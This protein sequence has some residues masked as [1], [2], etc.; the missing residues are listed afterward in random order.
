M[1][2][3]ASMLLVLGFSLIFMVVANNFN[4][5][6]V[7]A[8]DNFSVYY[9][10]TVAH[11]IAVSGANMAANQIFF[12]VNWTTGF[13]NLNFGGG[14]IDASVQIIDA[15]QNIRQVEVI[16]RYPDPDDPDVTWDMV[17]EDTV[18]VVL[19]P[20]KFSKFAYFS[21]YE[22]SNIWWTSGDT[23]W[24]P[25]HVQGNLRVNQSPVFFGKVTVENGVVSDGRWER[26][27]VGGHWERRGRGR[28]ARWVW[29][30]DYEWV[31]VDSADPKFY[32]GLETGIDMDLPPDGVA[33]LESA[34]DVGGAKFTG[35]D[36]VYLTFDDDSLRFRF[37]NN[38]PDT[39]V[40]LASFAPN[41]VIFADDATVRIKG[42]VEGQYTVGISGSSGRGNVFLD[43]D[44]IYKNDPRVDPTSSDLLGIVAQRDV[45]ITDNAA[46]HSDIE[47]H[48]SIYSEEGGFGSEN[49]ASRPNSGSINLLGGIIQ[50]TRRAVGTFNSWGIVSGFNKKYRYDDRLMTASPPHFPGT[51]SYEIVSWYE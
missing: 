26:R 4:R 51:G 25:M 6:T 20:S 28:R 39:T 13:N 19:Q 1:G 43:D 18:R 42:V 35:Q 16:G 21:A 14:E 5:I 34:A 40:E 36:S 12:D 2:G 9:E 27:E 11:N 7:D 49:Y 31:W 33:N 41:G 10:E 3:K 17:I 8:V 46:N 24:G 45:M 32:G 23:V 47:I 44:I 48:A 29:V 50:S 30:P 37:S 22:P 38:D 15:F